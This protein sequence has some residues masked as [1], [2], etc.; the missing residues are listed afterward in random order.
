MV[1]TVGDGGDGVIRLLGRKTSGNVQKVVWLLEELGLA[2]QREDYGRQFNNTADERYLGLNPAG[3]VPT[4]IDGDTVIWESNTILRYL[5]NQSGGRLYASAPAGRSAVERWMDWQLAGLDPA[6]L[7]VFREMRAAPHERSAQFPAT[8][9][10]LGQT[11][12]I[13]ERGMN[14]ARWV[15]GD[16]ITIADIA[17]GPSV[18]R[19]LGYDVD[20]PALENVRRW[21][22]AVAQRPAFR[23]ATE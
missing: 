19:C 21:H 5:A 14:G 10:A 17:L 2:Y 8:V 15:A 12:A 23:E 1:R 13:L 22:D 18:H 20:L 3:K 6:F 16:D 4:L 7:A 11:L 9:A